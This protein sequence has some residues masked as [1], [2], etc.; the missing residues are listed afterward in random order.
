MP[1]I[2]PCFCSD[3]RGL[4]QP[5][6]LPPQMQGRL[7]DGEKRTP[8]LINSNNCLVEWRSLGVSLCLKGEKDGRMEAEVSFH[9]Y[10]ISNAGNVLSI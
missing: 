4:H 2:R 9:E 8:L 1:C 3:G 10:G 7:F 6:R 5:A